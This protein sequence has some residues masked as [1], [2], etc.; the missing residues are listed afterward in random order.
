M[1]YSQDQNSYQWY[2]LYR[3]GVIHPTG[4]ELK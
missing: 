3:N 4:A 1:M 2:Q